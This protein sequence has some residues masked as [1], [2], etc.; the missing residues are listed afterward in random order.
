MSVCRGE[1]VR[2]GC[3]FRGT[4][5]LSTVVLP[6]AVCTGASWIGLVIRFAGRGRL[7]GTRR[8]RWLFCSVVAATTLVTVLTSTVLLPHASELPPVA[9]GLV[10]GSAVAPRQ[11]ARSGG[12]A[13]TA[14]FTFGI[15]HLLGLLSTRL[16]DDRADWCEEMTLG[17]TDGYALL[18][19]ASD[20]K[21]HLLAR[22]ESPGFG[23]T[24]KTLNSRKS[25]INTRFLEAK[26]AAERSIKTETDIEKALRS[27]G[28][29]ATQDE[30][31][32][33]LCRFGEAL[34]ACRLLLHPARDHGRR[35]S[36]RRLMTLRDQ[37]AFHAQPPAWREL[38]SP[39]SGQAEGSVL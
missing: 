7:S 29:Q 10:A 35:S 26:K 33:A 4:R 14:L 27:D 3:T 19:F 25:D 2:R 13:A 8:S 21:G 1:P 18:R 38:P 34:N 16:T 9:V 5:M 12:Q 22:L 11:R 24:A 31:M 15:S 30:R 6:A 37:A 36:D 17:L 28:R 39:R 32:Q 20:A 23:V